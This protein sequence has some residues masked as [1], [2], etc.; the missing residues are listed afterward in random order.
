MNQPPR[1]PPRDPNLDDTDHGLDRTRATGD[2]T[3]GI[4]PVTRVTQAQPPPPP[5]R[6]STQPLPRATPR[7]GRARSRRDSGLYLPLWS[8][9]LVLVIVMVTVG[10]LVVLVLSIGGNEAPE[11]PPVVIVSSP[12]PT[13]PPPEGVAASPATAPS[14]PELDPISGGNAPPPVPPLRMAGPT[15]PAVEF[16]AT[17]M[18]IAVGRQVRVVGV[19]VQQLNVRDEPGVT[20]STVV[21]R[22]EEDSTFNVVGGPQQADGLT[23][24]QIEDPFNLTR[25]GWAASNYLHAFVA[26]DSA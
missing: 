17:P 22:A 12:V 19:G 9:A 14:P 16:T 20:G 4:P 13:D 24:W 1:E 7:R 21:F 15:L 23:W 6:R 10:G 26:D 18:T 5:P 2:R 3:R 8:L 25:T 11:A